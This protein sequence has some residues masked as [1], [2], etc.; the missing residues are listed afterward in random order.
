MEPSA[1]VETASMKSFNLADNEKPVDR[2]VEPLYPSNLIEPNGPAKPPLKPIT[3]VDLM[4]PTEAKPTVDEVVKSEVVVEEQKPT[5]K[6][7][8]KLTKLCCCPLVVWI[9]CYFLICWLATTFVTYWFAFHWEHELMTGFYA[10]AIMFSVMTILSWHVH[11]VSYG[12][13]FFFYILLIFGYIIFGLCAVIML[14]EDHYQKIAHKRWK[15]EITSNTW[16]L[17][18]LGYELGIFFHLAVAFCILVA[19]MDLMILHQNSSH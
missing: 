11:R 3:S 19:W 8:K 6:K 14:Y 18:L 17:L 16:A 12:L 13:I 2:K 1:P 7:S 5:S 9:I 10:P 4:S 15:I